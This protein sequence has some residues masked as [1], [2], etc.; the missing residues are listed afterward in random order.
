M[1]DEAHEGERAPLLASFFPLLDQLAA[2]LPA[3]ADHTE[4]VKMAEKGNGVEI[5]PFN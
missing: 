3:D 1:I 5:K 2:D 4:I